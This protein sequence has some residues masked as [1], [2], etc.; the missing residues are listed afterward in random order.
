MTYFGRQAASASHA[1]RHEDG[2]ADEI[3]VDS[4]SGELADDQPPKS[5]D[6]AGAD[7][8]ADTLADLN[9]KVSDATLDGSGASRTPSAHSASHE[10]GGGDEIDVSGLTGAGGDG[11]L[12]DG[13]A[14]RVLRGFILAIVDGTNANTL[15]CTVNQRWNGDVISETDNIAKGATTGD[16]NL[17]ADG[18]NLL[19]KATGLTGNALFAIANLYSNSTGT[20][21]NSPCKALTNDILVNISDA[22]SAVYQDIT[23]VADSGG[24]YIDILYITSE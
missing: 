18:K 12:G 17:S 5:H 21:Y 2:G 23:V 8:N 11:I 24:I 6:L 14:G 22:G 16:F 9:L 19:I 1:S 4:L 10:N 15:K 7:H 13:V 20:D 3:S